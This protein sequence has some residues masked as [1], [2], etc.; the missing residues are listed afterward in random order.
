MKESPN[1]YAVVTGAG[2]GLGKAYALQLARRGYNLILVSLPNEKLNEFA[3]EISMVYQ[4]H[5]VFWETDLTISDNLL[6]LAHWINQNFMISLLVNNAGIG[7]S[8]SFLEANNAYINHI[9][10]LNVSATSLLTKELLPNLLKNRTS[11]V[12]NVSSMAAFIPT[13]YKTVYPATKSFI[14]SFSRGLNAELAEKGVTV[15]V[16]HPGPMKTNREISSRIEKQGWFAKIL[17]NDPEKVAKLSL[18]GL[19]KKKT[20]IVPS[21]WASIL[22]QLIPTRVLVPVLT[23]SI[24]KELL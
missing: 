22:L 6:S 13:G 15:C 2:S 1:S 12:L 14:S 8:C 5:A 24:K 11:Y 20:V 21:Q 19:F 16:V 4:V 10:Q 18:D 9:I 3:A 23:D 7:G 17:L